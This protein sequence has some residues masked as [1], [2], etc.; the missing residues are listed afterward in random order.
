[1]AVHEHDMMHIGKYIHCQTNNHKLTANEICSFTSSLQVSADDDS[2]SFVA[3]ADDDAAAAMIGSTM[4]RIGL[5]VRRLFL[6]A[7]T[8]HNE[9]VVLSSLIL[10]MIVVDGAAIAVVV[11]DV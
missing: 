10:L 8:S 1:M 6:D 2:S 5:R 3:D 4:A 11:V 9:F 7:G